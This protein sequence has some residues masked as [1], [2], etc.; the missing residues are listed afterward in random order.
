[1]NQLPTED[2][3]INSRWGYLCCISLVIITVCTMILSII[4][5]TSNSKS[6]QP[7][8]SYSKP[9]ITKDNEPSKD[10]TVTVEGEAEAFPYNSDKGLAFTFLLRTS[11]GDIYELRPSDTI[12]SFHLN[13]NTHTVYR[14]QGRLRSNLG[15]APV[16]EISNYQV[17]SRRRP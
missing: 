14:I 9:G 6:P 4:G 17:I 8:S 2:G 13:V 12:K 16:I 3:M 11:K 7:K 1:M 15:P 10:V 5:C